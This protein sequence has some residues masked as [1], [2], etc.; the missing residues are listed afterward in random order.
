[1]LSSKNGKM[2][3]SHKSSNKMLIFWNYLEKFSYFETR[4]LE[5]RVSMKNLIWRK[6]SYLK[7]NYMELEF[8][9]FYF[10]FLFFIYFFFK[11]WWLITQLSKNR[12]FHWKNKNI[13]LNS[14]RTKGV[15]SHFGLCYLI[16]NEFFYLF[17]GERRDSTLLGSMNLDVICFPLFHFWHCLR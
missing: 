16:N 1:M 8:H 5:N 3:I 10:I 15:Y 17:Y 11:V 2:L 4:F 14:F 13:F 6:L 12:V 7:K 9:L